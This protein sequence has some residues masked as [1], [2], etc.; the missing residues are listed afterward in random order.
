MITVTNPIPVAQDD[1]ISASEDD[2]QAMGSVFAGNGNGPDIDVDGDDLS[3]VEVDGVAANLGQAIAGSNGGLFTINPDG[4]YVFDANGEFEGLDV[5]ESA[6]TS[7]TYLVSDGEGGTDTATVTITVQGQN[8]APVVIDPANPNA[9]NPTIPTQIGNDSEAMPPLDLSD[10]F[11]DPDVERTFFDLEDAPSWLSV[12]PFTGVVTG[13]PPLD[14]SQNGPLNNGVY[15][16]TVVAS[17]PDGVETRVVVNFTIANPAPIAQDDFAIVSENGSDVSGNVISLDTGSGIDS[18][19]DGDLLSVAALDGNP[20]L[21]GTPT[22]GSIGGEFIVNS[23]GSYSFSP[24]GDFEYL[25]VGETATTTLS[26]LLTDADGATDMAVISVTVEG[27]NDSPIA[28]DPTQPVG[29]NN[30][31]DPSDP[32][33]PRDP[34]VDPQDYIPAQTGADGTPFT[35]IDLTPYFGD[36]DGTDAITLSIDP[37]SLPDG[38]VFDGTT[39]SGTPTADASQGGISGVYDVTVTATDP[40]GATFSTVVEITITNPAPIAADDVEMTDEDTVLSDSVMIDNTNGA[41]TDFDGDVLTVAQVNGMPITSGAVITLPSG[42]LL[43]MNADGSYD[44]DPNGQFENLAGGETRDDSFSYQITDSQGGFS[45]ATVNLTVEGVNDAPIAIDP[46]QP[47]G[48]IDPSDP[49]DPQDPRDPPVDPQNY[50]PAQIAT[51]SAPVT[52]LDLTPYFGDPD[53]TDA[54]TLSLNPADL[55]AGLVFDGTSIS[56]TPSSDAS[57]GGNDGVY[58]VAVTATDPSG[59][60]FTTNVVYTL[61]NPAPVAEND[62]ITTAEDTP[63][64]VNLITNSDVDIDGDVLIVD[65]VALPD[66]TI[67]PVG[68]ATE[69]PQGTLTVLVDGT[70][71]FEPAADLFGPVVF[72]YTVSDG[73]GG[74]DVATVTIN[75]TPVND[76][77]IAVDPTQPVAEPNNPNFPTDPTAPYEPPVDTMN[78]IPVQ[79]AEDGALVTPLDLTPYFGDPDPM[80]VLTISLDPADLPSGLIFDPATGTISGTP[81]SDASQGGDPLNPGIYIVPVTVTDPSGETFTTNVTY[82]LSNP[83]PIAQ[84]D[85]TLPVVEDVSTIL[86]LIGNDVDV[87]GDDLTITEINGTLVIVGVP[88]TL[89]SGAVVTV[90]G[91]G[92]VNYEPVPD[93]NGPDGFTYTISDGEGGTDTASVTVDVTP[94]NDS[95]IVTSTVPGQAALP[96]QSSFDGDEIS[97]SVSGPFSDI[98]GDDLTFTAMGLPIGL[99]IDPVTGEISGTLPAGASADGPYVVTI[100]GTD[101]SGEAVSTDFTWTVENVNPEVVAPLTDVALLDGANVSIPTAASFADSDGDAVTYA[102]SG[103]PT[104]LSI[105]P[106]TGEIFGVVDGSASQSGPYNVAVTATDS[107]GGSV[108]DSFAVD[109]ANQAPDAID[110]AL[111]ANEDASIT[112]HIIAGSDV[113]VDGDTLVVTEVDGDPLNLG[114]AIAGTNGGLFTIDSTGAVIFDTNGEYDGLDVGETVTTSVTYEISDGEGGTDSATVTVTVTGTNDAPITTGTFGTQANSDGTEQLPLDTS[115]IFSDV[116][117]EELTFT[118]ADLPNWM[119]LDPVSGILTGTPPADASQGG[120]NAD[121]VYVVNITATDPDGESVT[122]P[123]VYTFSNLIPDAMNDDL[124]SDEDTS[125]SGNIL[126]SNDVDADGDVLTVSAVD[127]NAINVGRPVEG[128]QGGEFTINS[129]GSYEF[130]P[131]GDF[132]ALAA[133][134]IATTTI[135]Y[136]VSD[137]EGGTDVAS[138]TVTVTGTN[139]GPI[140]VDPTQPAGSIGDPNVPVDPQDPHTPPL[141]PNNYIPAQIASD[142]TTVAPLDL[143]PYFGDPDGSDAVTLSIVPADLPPGLTFDGTT[144]SGTPTANA[145]LSGRNGV[146]EVP[147]TATDSIGETFTTLVTYTI[148]N[149]APVVDAPIGPLTAVDNGV[150]SI[151]PAISDPDGDALTYSVTG[152]PT[153][154]SIIPSTGEIV[155]TLDNSASQGGPNADGA[156]TISVTADDGQGGTVTDTFELNISNSAPIAA[157][158]MFTANEGML[159]TGTVI[160]GSDTDIDQDE[161]TVSEVAGD[162]ANVGAPVAG[163]NGGQFTINAD[164]SLTFDQNGEFEALEVGETAIS[165]ITYTISDGEGGTDTATVSVTIEGAN[166]APVITGPLVAQNGTDGTPL[167]P[168]DA[169]VAFTDIDGETLTYSAIDLPVGLNIDPVTGVISGTPL[170]NASQGGANADGVYVVEII[171]TDPGGEDVS[172]FVTYTIENTTPVAG[173]DVFSTLEDTPISVNVITA[174]DADADGDALSVDAAALPNGD[175]LPIGSPIDLPEGE[176]TIWADGTVEFVPTR[177]FYGTLIFGYTV[178]DS[179]GGTDVATVTFDVTPVSDVPIPVDPTQPA[180][181]PNNPNFPTDPDAPFAPP[182]DPENYIPVQTAADGTPVAPIDLTPY[183]GSPDP[184]EEL[185]ISVDPADLPEGLV[186]DPTTGVISGT[187]VPAAS[188]GGDPLNPGTYIV[189]VTATDS[190]GETFTTNLTYILGNLPPVAGVDANLSV[191][192]DTPTVLDLIGNDVDSDGDVLT[193]T[194]INGTPITVDVPTTLPSG[195]IVTLNS[196]GSVSYD[197]VADYNGP[198]SFSYTISDGEGGTDIAT[199]ALDVTPVNDGP[200]VTPTIPGDAALPPQFNVDGATVSVP[201]A[202]P[203]SDIDDNPLTFTATGLPDGLSIDPITGIVSGTLSASASTDGPYTVI[204][205]AMDTDGETVSTEFVWTVE[206]ITPTVVTPLADVAGL[207]GGEVFIPTADNFVDGDGDAVAFAATGLPDGLSIDPETGVISGTIAGSASQSGPYTVTVTVT[208]AQGEI[209]ESTFVL[210]VENP[211][212]VVSQ[213]IMPVTAPVVG[214]NVLIDVGAATQ[215]PDGDADLTYSADDLPPGLS[216]DPKTGI[217]SGVPKEPRAE[218]Y[219]FTVTV[220]D[221]EGGVTEVVLSLQVNEDGYVE[222]I[223]PELTLPD[224]ELVDPYEFLEGQPIDLQRYFHDRALDARDDHGRMFGDRDFRGGMVIVNVPGMGED[225]AYMVVEAVANDHNVTVSMGSTFPMVCDVTVKSWDIRMADGSQVPSWVD[226]SNGADSMDIT[227]PLDAETIRLQ[228][229]ALLDNGRT[230]STTVEV[231]LRTGIVTQVGNAY[232]QGQTL[233]Q[234][235]TLE[236]MALREQ[237]AEVDVAQDAL[238]RALA[239]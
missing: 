204:V 158:D 170:A 184:L 129:D 36:P 159:L 107:Q 115:T 209:A 75:V 160:L 62:V 228:V 191:V 88:T 27:A 85:G 199:V 87:D 126:T 145:S 114:Q 185:T 68:I 200:V 40:S 219:V 116:D 194:A 161:L 171:A 19:I 61:T 232:A 117:G 84:A 9:A 193:I 217:I 106:A 15:P 225:C 137:G 86:E 120:P 11:A 28:V 112:G 81:T 108:T 178:S 234:Q 177:D 207:D 37:T 77:P 190:D 103:L 78:Y 187:P 136:Q 74:T 205:T 202:G 197:P 71:T 168:L 214:E 233:Q 91:D 4:T 121:G 229:R 10:Y 49:S 57:Q 80:E 90:I 176:L 153:G 133:G 102:A 212:P 182:V 83:A 134:E 79:S 46:T 93:Y 223:E 156:Y 227:R 118:S 24:N 165:T 65:A 172:T 188:Q 166:D 69:I 175:L 13:T 221:G 130:D 3:V 211:A 109:V 16:V 210:S 97:V 138:V 231:D 104:G 8:D 239:G 224:V 181:E 113:D 34:P 48:P 98:D 140:A 1:A 31:A 2:T 123:V 110:D 43:T 149:I 132:N 96:P 127:G 58:I 20:A 150:V 144:I 196:D 42:A 236:A 32:Q 89:P 56:G 215:D 143:T 53:G 235:M 5:G 33:D 41:D 189:P 72:G 82:N 169:S 174:S 6:T 70:A 63:V 198:D 22:E 147:V 25:A 195:A 179:Q 50:I 45:I 76:T 201:L 122:S 18:D 220:T 148:E 218:P 14:A 35:P 192:E 151:V 21:V 94:V 60:T 139:D 183:F 163:S 51:D 226:W 99:A 30:P 52:P 141:D 92:T 17:D 131:T 154:L 64:T 237:V 142:N 119:S 152:L 162:P 12:N 167:T 66:G 216:I 59:E 73:Q 47:V 23:D 100:T 124:E 208:D 55:P 7:V 29:P 164:G 213:P 157:D 135:T 101:P 111:S 206:N 38:L 186:F 173:T 39:L 54:L 26:Y 203:F 67:V 180:A 222:P 125:L 105:D 238:L 146:F 155:G 128:S 230:T 44:Y 95:P